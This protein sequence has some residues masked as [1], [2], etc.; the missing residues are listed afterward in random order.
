MMPRGNPRLS[1]VAVS[2]QDKTPNYLIKSP[3]LLLGHMAHWLSHK[4]GRYNYRAT[5]PG[6]NC[7]YMAVRT[8]KLRVTARKTLK[9]TSGPS[10]R[11]LRVTFR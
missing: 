1:H 7:Q 6:G 5:V 10:G 9:A 11:Y 4:C 2:L 3:Y 8:L